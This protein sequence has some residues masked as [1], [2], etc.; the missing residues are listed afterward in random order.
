MKYSYIISYTHETIGDNAK[1]E[2]VILMK[3]D[4]VVMGDCHINL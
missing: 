1:F 3:T 4:N 2:T